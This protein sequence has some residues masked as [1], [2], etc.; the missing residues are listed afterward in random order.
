M[1]EKLEFRLLDFKSYDIRGDNGKDFIVQM[2]GKNEKKESA[3]IIVKNIEPFFYVKVG[4][5]WNPTTARGFLKEIKQTL[6]KKE[7]TDNY[8][9]YINGDQT[10]ISPKL[11]DDKESLKEYVRNN[12]KSYQSYVGKGIVSF[13][14]VEKHKLYG[15]DNHSSYN[16]IKVTVTS[17]YCFNKL[18]NLW[19]DRYEDP[20]SRFGFSQTLKTINYRGFE[21]ELYEAKLPPLLRFFHI[22]NISPSGWIQIKKFKTVKNK[23]MIL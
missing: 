10:H 2:F 21:T 22:N 6:S 20:T 17:T 1:S 8:N 15:F 19:F 11:S 12:Y 14:I 18:K 9:R 7:L 23:Q 13:D 5:K 4:A 16:F 3:S